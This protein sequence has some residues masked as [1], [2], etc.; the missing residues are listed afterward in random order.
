MIALALTA[1]SCN[2]A[3]G[4]GD[5]DAGD[6]I[7]HLGKGKQIV[8][9]DLT[10]EEDLN[11]YQIKPM[12]ESITTKRAYVDASII[13]V[14]CTFKGQVNA[15]GKDGKVFAMTTFNKGVC[16]IDCQ[17]EKE[18]NFRSANITG[19]ANFTGSVFHAGASFQGAVFAYQSNYFE[20]AQFHGQ[21]KFQR[22]EF[23][24]HVTFAACEFS[25][26]SFQNAIFRKDANFGGVKLMDY[27]DF[28]KLTAFGKMHFQYAEGKKT[29]FNGS[30]FYGPFD[31]INAKLYGP[32]IFTGAV[33]HDQ[34]RF[35]GSY[36]QQS[37]D[38][39]GAR[40]LH[41]KPETAELEI[42][43]GAQ[44]ITDKETYYVPL[45]PLNIE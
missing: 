25:K 4:R 39:G 45:E 40:F 21:A 31:L 32:F 15:Y 35:S 33:F 8:L 19:L 37:I 28:S 38:L 36:V 13:F 30:R 7:K 24:G 1:S 16:F 29:N 27:A 23:G 34:C 43:T 6:I 10:F 17:F 12:R 14:N 5:P 42:G 2:E 26:S 20:R 44:L 3:T 41:G 18:V 22:A 11:F 9:R